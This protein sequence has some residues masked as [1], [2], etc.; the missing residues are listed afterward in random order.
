MKSIG[1]NDIQPLLLAKVLAI[2]LIATTLTVSTATALTTDS[3]DKLAVSVAIKQKTIVD[4]SPASLSWDN[5]L[6]P[7]SQGNEKPIQIEN[8]G[9]VNITHVWFNN[10]AP[11][12][13][14]FGTGQISNYDSGNWIAIRNDSASANP[15]FISRKEFNATSRIIYLTGPDGNTPPSHPYGRFMNAS[16]EYFWSVD[17]GTGN[18][19][20]GTIYIGNTPHTASQT[21]DADLSGNAGDTLSYVGNGWGYSAV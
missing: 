21:G 6:E 11:S 9:S 16:K 18:C 20:D 4:V 12:Q 2:T 8:L 3:T 15:Y 13:R 14:P 17:C 10:S 19:T 7:G 5:P 1:N